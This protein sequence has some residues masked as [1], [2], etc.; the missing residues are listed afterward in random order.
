MKS[1]IKSDT[2]F[3]ER[4]VT[5]YPIEVRKVQGVQLKEIPMG[6][7]K[8]VE[9]FQ[10]IEEPKEITVTGY[11]T[12]KDQSA[13]EEPKEI[14]VTGYPSRKFT[15]IEDESKSGATANTPA[16]YNIST[17][18]NIYPNPTSNLVQ[19]PVSSVKGGS[20]LLQVVDA[21]GNIVLTQRPALSKGSNTVSINTTSLKTGAYVIKLTTPEGTSRSYKMM[22]K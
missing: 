15:T 22:K 16:E 11:R 10:I 6:E 4:V 5:G 17:D 2:L 21:A 3:E 18:G 19:V 8:K 1:K 7:L 14:V 13:T 12:K 20:G 9:G